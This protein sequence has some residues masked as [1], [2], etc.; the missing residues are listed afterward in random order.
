MEKDTIS[1]YS[2]NT[3]E[4][5]Q[6]LSEMKLLLPQRKLLSYYPFY[7]HFI[8]IHTKF[9]NIVNNSTGLVD[10][11]NFTSSNLLLLKLNLVKNQESS[12]IT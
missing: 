9:E 12:K 7:S 6:M 11:F 10:V 4:F 2:A 3:T 8:L 5:P 1:V